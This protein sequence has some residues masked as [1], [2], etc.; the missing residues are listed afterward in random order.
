MFMFRFNHG[1]KERSDIWFGPESS[2]VTQ[3]KP[4]EAPGQMLVL[5]CRITQP[6][7]ISC[8]CVCVVYEWQLFLHSRWGGFYC[9]YPRAGMQTDAIIAGAIPVSKLTQRPACPFWFH[10]PTR[11]RRGCTGATHLV[12]TCIRGREERLSAIQPG[13]SCLMEK[14]CPQSSMQCCF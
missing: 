1:S 2:H 7:C 12:Q 11:A 8:V 14:L 6:V 9:Y 3:L 10:F 5:T 4:C 13:R